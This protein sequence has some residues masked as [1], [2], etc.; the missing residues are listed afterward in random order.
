[1]IMVGGAGPGNPKYLTMDVYERIKSCEIVIAFGRISETLKEIR[2]DIIPV[3]FVAEVLEVANENKNKDILIL[4]SGDPNF[5]GIVKFLKKNNLPIDA[6]LPGLSSF[7][8]FMAKL[9]LSWNDANLLSLH[10][11]EMSLE[12][13]KE[14]EKSV[15]LTDKEH[16]P[17]YISEKLYEMGIKGTLI[18]GYNLSYDEEEVIK[19]NIGEKIEKT[20][21]LAIVVILNEMD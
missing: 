10:G 14:Y 18:A 9:G 5:Y 19:I 17:S 21:P 8:Y 13:I 4:A 11:R 3:K 15:I 12:T 1:M 2:E 6:I 16:T 7:Q 20:S